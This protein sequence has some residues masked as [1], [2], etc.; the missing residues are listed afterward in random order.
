MSSLA[1]I[2]GSHGV[3]KG[4]TCKEICSQTDLIHITASEVLKWNE[5]SDLN[6]KNVEDIGDTQDRLVKGLERVVEKGKR[7][8]LDGHFCL[9]NSKG[10]VERVPMATFKKISPSMLLV[11]TVQTKLVKER[12]EKK[13]K[14]LYDLALL[15]QMQSNE[16]KY[17]K[18]IA[19]ELSVPY[20]K[21]SDGNF[22]HLPDILK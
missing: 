12:L 13:D 8:L 10:E 3:G 19:S 20:F 21:I 6:N 22:E 2:G 11:V 14:K 4:T 9:F 7:Y 15:E 5:I 1:F 16:V 17:A 18:E